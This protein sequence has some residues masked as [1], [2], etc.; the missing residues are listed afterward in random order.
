MHAND[1]ESDDPLSRLVTLLARRMRTMSTADI[2]LFEEQ[3]NIIKNGDD[4][5][6]IGLARMLVHKILHA[7]RDRLAARDIPFTPNTYVREDY[8][9][10]EITL[11][12]ATMDK[13]QLSDDYKRKMTMAANDVAGAMARS[14]TLQYAQRHWP[15]MKE[16]QKIRALKIVQHLHQKHQ[17]LDDFR[18]GSLTDLFFAHE[19]C[20]KPNGQDNPHFFLATHRSGFNRVFNNASGSRFATAMDRVGSKIDYNTHN[21]NY[22]FMR[23]FAAAAGAMHHEQQHVF[24]NALAMAFH[25]KMIDQHHPH[26]NDAR[27]LH[28]LTKEEC[29]M[30]GNIISLYRTQAIEDDAFAFQTAMTR[31]LYRPFSQGVWADD[32]QQCDAYK[33]SGCA[34]FKKL[35][36]RI[37]GPRP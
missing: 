10:L 21:D 11:I 7:E 6:R 25:D 33:N 27:V 14:K 17:T 19:P 26:Y 3:I 29:Y 36:A 28:L 30:P 12:R 5:S 24:Q 32:P 18:C 2:L 8:Y 20:I 4:R 34:L 1:N 16:D 35:K 15:T 23:S 31:R 37:F 13:F 9:P 22:Y